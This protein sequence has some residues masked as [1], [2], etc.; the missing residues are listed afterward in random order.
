MLAGFASRDITPKPG[1]SMTGFAVRNGPPIALGTHDPLYVHALAATADGAT[2]LLFSFDLIGLP[3]S[4]I[5]GAR[6]A[7]ESECSVPG[8]SQMY[9]CTHTHCGPGTGVLP[10]TLGDTQAVDPA[11]MN[12]LVDHVVSVARD[13]LDGAAQAKLSLGSG[14]SYAG[15]NRRS[16]E[17]SAT[18]PHDG[19]IDEI[20]SAVVVAQFEGEGGRLLGTVVNYGCHATSSRD[21]CYSSDYPG[22]L[23]SAVEAHTGAPCLYVNGAGGD[24]NP[25]GATSELRSFELAEQTGNRLA[26]D[27]LAII[28]SMTSADS[29]TVRTANAV[30]EL[31]Y[32]ELISEDEARRIHAEGVAA[33][34][35]VTSPRAEVESKWYG[36]EYAARV[37]AALKDTNWSDRLQVDVQV[38]RIGDLAIAAFPS[39]F[40]SADGRTVR[41][42]SPAPFTMVA[43]WSN[44]LFGYTPTRRAVERGGYEVEW[45]FKNY[46]HPAAWD[47]IS[48]DNLRAAAL[49][50]TQ[51]LLD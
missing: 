43:C 39:E 42:D 34:N 24:V 8:S 50:A 33:S 51:S 37:I 47:P 30:A 35:N 18:G 25:R 31:V 26:N 4:W 20:D 41:I 1:L 17:A 44:G 29:S 16:A 28:A 10:Y 32:R 12:S 14:E 15:W 13:A 3:S 46:G 48:A 7:V 49:N 19:H 11:F 22:Y 21:S 6:K 23:R 5:A 40:F 38:I 2:V 36:T 27:A 45:A 9:T